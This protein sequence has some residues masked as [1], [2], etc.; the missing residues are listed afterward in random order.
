MI[1]YMC[2]SNSTKSSLY[3]GCCLMFCPLAQIASQKG[4]EPDDMEDLKKLYLEMDLSELI[5]MLI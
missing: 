2:Q 4:V 3:V 1:D 5:I